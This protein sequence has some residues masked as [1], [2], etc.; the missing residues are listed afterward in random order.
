VA[1]D[2]CTW[3]GELGCVGADVVAVDGLNAEDNAQDTS[4]VGADGSTRRRDEGAHGACGMNNV[5]AINSVL[6][7]T[8]AMQ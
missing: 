6:R 4:S 8:V 1:S 7:P 2:A 5:N 3:C